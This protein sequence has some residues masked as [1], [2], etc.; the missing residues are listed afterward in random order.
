M[1]GYTSGTETGLA[2]LARPDW[3]I[4]QASK[5]CK[6]SGPMGALES[7]GGEGGGGD[8]KQYGVMEMELSAA[9]RI[10]GRCQPEQ[11][12]RESVE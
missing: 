8:A 5:C 4:S 9:Q 10:E 2:R 7:G 11:E 1:G 6:V 3:E 12:W